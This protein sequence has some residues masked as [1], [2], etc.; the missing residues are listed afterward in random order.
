MISDGRDVKRKTEKTCFKILS[1]DS[2][3]KINRQRSNSLN[4][5]LKC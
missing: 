4:K 3:T 5:G 2:A 1:T